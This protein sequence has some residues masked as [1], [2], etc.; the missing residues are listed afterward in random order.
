VSFDAEDLLE[1]YARGVFPMADSREDEELFLVDPERRGVL[2]LDRFHVP[3]RLARTVRADTYEVRFDTAF[4]DVVAACADP[5]PGHPETWINAPI[6]RMYGQLHR[7]GHAHSVECWS[8]DELVGGLYGVS[9]RAAFFGESMFSRAR[10]AS[11][12]A[13]VHLVARL[14][15]GGYRLLDT[16]FLTEHLTQFGAEEISRADYR[17]RLAASLSLDAHFYGV[18]GAPGA[19]ASAEGDGLSSGVDR[20][21]AGATGGFAFGAEGGA[22]AGGGAAGA[23]AGAGAL[24]VINQAS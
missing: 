10:D 4:A 22:L 9:L 20:V 18:G 13:L 6:R 12:V 24:Q 23:G 21:G 5:R 17:R 1:C 19:A 11:K 2:R 16:Q 15:V 3:R 14:I 7:T 8:G